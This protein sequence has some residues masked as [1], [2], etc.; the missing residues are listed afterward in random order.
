MLKKEFG[1]RWVRWALFSLFSRNFGMFYDVLMFWKWRPPAAFVLHFFGPGRHACPFGPL[2]PTCRRTGEVYCLYRCRRKNTK[3]HGFTWNL[4]MVNCKLGWMVL[5]TVLVF[6]DTMPMFFLEIT[7][8]NNW[9]YRNG[10]AF[11]VFHYNYCR[12]NPVGGKFYPFH[13]QS[14]NIQCLYIA[15]YIYSIASYFC[16]TGA[17]VPHESNDLWWPTGGWSPPNPSVLTPE[18]PEIEDSLGD[19]AQRYKDTVRSDVIKGPGEGLVEF[20]IGILLSLL[21]DGSFSSEDSLQ[22]AVAKGFFTSNVAGEKLKEDIK[23]SKRGLLQVAWLISRINGWDPRCQVWKPS[24][25]SIFH[26]L[27]YG[28]RHIHLHQ[29]FS[30]LLKMG[31][32]TSFPTNPICNFWHQDSWF[33]NQK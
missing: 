22:I 17:F 2:G 18:D 20:G 23:D 28:V 4:E 12:P 32:F 33:L 25:C 19:M 15:F 14:N 27:C 3:G 1:S 10:A 24:I 26:G 30:H 21:E 7:L 13:R 5:K 16:N 8:T 31:F 6:E 11:H 9:M 29:P